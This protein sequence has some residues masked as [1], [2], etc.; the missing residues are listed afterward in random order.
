M[1]IRL[2]QKMDLFDSN[3]HR[4]GKIAIE[5]IE[6]NLLSGTFEP[7]SAFATV[8]RLFRQFEEAVDVQAL[9]VVEKLDSA[10]A[11]LGLY[12]VPPEGTGAF[13]IH[14]VQIWSDR[15]ISLRIRDPGKNGQSGSGVFEKAVPAS[16]DPKHGT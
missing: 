10:I 9:G 15:G 5:R 1:A 4:L 13:A 14:D 6:G 3:H 8:E 16:T 2:D 11:S 7:G 12:L